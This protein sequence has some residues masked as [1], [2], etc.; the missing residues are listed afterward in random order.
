MAST[1]RGELENT[2]LSL[3]GKTARRR[4][5]MLTGAALIVY[6]GLLSVGRAMTPRA[7]AAVPNTPPPAPSA[8]PVAATPTVPPVTPTPT[9][10]GE[11]PD[12][13]ENALRRR[14]VYTVLIVGRDTVGLN[15]DTIMI[16]R[17]DSAEK[18]LDVVSLPRDTLVNVPWSVKKVN[19][20]YG[21]RGTEGLLDGIAGLIGFPVDNYA[22]VNTAAFR[23]MIDAV[24]GVDYDVPMDMHYDDGGQGLHI[25]LSAGFQHLDGAA[26]EQLVRFRQN[27]N[28]TGYADGDLGRIDLQH[29]FLSAA[30]RQILSVKNLAA[31]PAL[32]RIVSENT[33][34]DLTLGNMAFFAREL[35][36]LDADSVRFYTAP[37]DLAEIRGGSYVSL[38][39]DEWLELINSALNPFTVPITAEN[40]D[41]LTWGAGG[42]SSTR[43]NAPG[44]WTFFDY[45]SL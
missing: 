40:L 33:E 21:F 20:L 6:L 3:E 25:S 23:E 39:R 36:R 9:P 18:C 19:S 35:M 24:G 12:T 4:R 29:D 5:V 15:T 38:R 22:I 43:G 1:P 10:E 42:L 17:L 13:G 30:A 14:G 28:G 34:T 32:G 26:C 45:S 16:A 7:A 11:A 31:W 2:L 37:H 27:N 44:I 41:L 8:N